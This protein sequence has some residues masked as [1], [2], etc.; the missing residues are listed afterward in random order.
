MK[1]LE[2]QPRPMLEGSKVPGKRGKILKKKR[3][4]SEKKFR[5]EKVVLL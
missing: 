3:R 5:R 2:G 1:G 4:G